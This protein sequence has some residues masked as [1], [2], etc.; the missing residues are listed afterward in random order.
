M[1]EA[2]KGINNI[3]HD[4]L[5][6]YNG[7]MNKEVADDQEFEDD[8]PINIDD[9]EPADEEL[10]LGEITGLLN[11]FTCYF[12]QMHER[13]QDST[14]FDAIDNEKMDST[15]RCLEFMYE[16]MFKFNNS[17]DEDKDMLYDVD[18]DD[19]DINLVDELYMLS[20]DGVPIYV[21]KF[22]LTLIRYLATQKWNEINWSILPLKN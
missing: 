20:I 14:M 17:K 3:I 9:Y 5:D 13:K 4:I 7:D 6:N 12:K 19:L 22:R 16:E 18:D 2:N 1:E 11:I 21:S 15:N 10:E 8:E